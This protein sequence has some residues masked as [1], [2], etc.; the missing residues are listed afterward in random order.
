[1]ADNNAARQYDYLVIGGGSGGI[2]SANRAGMHGAKVGLIEANDLG[3][4]CVNLG[5]VPKKVMWHVSELMEE[6]GLYAEDYGI[7][8]T[9]SPNLDFGRM[10]DNRQAFIARLHTAYKNGLDSNGVELIQGY[11]SFV[12]PH[13]VEVNG[14]Y[15]TADRI[16]IATGG[17]PKRPN[18]PGSEFGIV[19][20]DVFKLKTLPERIA[21]V[22]GGYIGVEMSG[23]FHG[24]KVDTHQFIRKPKPLHGFDDI[25]CKGFVEIAEAE[26]KKVHTN[27][28]VK[29][30]RQNDDQSYTMYFEDGSTH[31]T[32][33]ILWATGRNP[34]TDSLNI[35]AAGVNVYPDGYIEVDQ[36]QNT[37]VDH[38]FA[39][40][41][42]TG[43]VELTPVA[44]AAGRRLSER[45]FNGKTN[46][47]LDYTNIPTVFF[48][49][50]PIG[51][52]GMTE[53]QAEDEY[54]KD[55]I[56]VYQTT[57]TSM[58][59]SITRN[60]QKTYMKLV[61]AGVEEK[62]VGLHGIGRGMD[63]MLQGFA[64]AIKMGATKADFDS[65][66]AIHPTAAE[67]FVTMKG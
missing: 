40:G 58:H 37:T 41:D 14:E 6:I 8:L 49:H 26:G 18:I 50:P 27:K 22:G 31:E 65:T 7:E 52:V 55:H 30:V 2:A 10:A 12:D 16:L 29:E 5:C 45:L 57:F 48:T 35:E 63:E 67:E 36:Y 47:Y 28:S 42:V 38:I 9:E 56:K 34:N 61:C 23:I 43:R 13:T 66:V 17:R 24:F 51:T 21:V 19:S 64:V 15:Y 32:D 33:Q 60:R 4:T 1:M 11:A 25:I 62:V 3:G 54:G 46:L 39:V 53:E 20:D 59:S 44:I